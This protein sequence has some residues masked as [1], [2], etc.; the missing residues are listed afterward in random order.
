MNPRTRA[1]GA[2]VAGGLLAGAAVGATEALA[3]WMHAH[4]AG[5]PPA[6][7]WALVAYGLVGG[8]LGLGAGVLAAVLGTDGFGLGLAGVGAALGFAVAR[9]RVIR[10]VFLEQL[11][12]GPVPLLVQLGALAAVAAAGFALWR[13]LRGADGRRAPLTRPVVAG[14][15]VLLLAAA[16]A[17]GARLWPAP[18]AAAV[19][20]RAAAPAGAP[21]VLLIMV[22][23]LR[24]DHLSCYGS[25]RVRTP[26]I[27]AL[28]AG[29]LRCANT[30][31]QASWTRP[32]VATILT[33]LYPSSHGAIH[34]A[35]ILPDRVDTL[36][37]MLQRGG[38]RTI[39]FANNANV[40]Q[41]FN[42]QQG[43]DEYHYLAPDF[44]FGASE[45]AAQLALYSGLRLVRE[46]FL[47]RRVDVHNYYQPA[48]TVTGEVRRWL[49]GHPA[50][51]EPLF[52][53]VH[54]MDP[55]DPYFVHPFNGEGY[56][57][58]AHPNPPPEMADKLHGLY[59]GSVA[60]LDE[61]L[62]VLFDDLRKR[63]LY[64]RTLV[65]LT[66][67]HGEEFHEHGGWWHGT[68]LYD[69]Q[70]HVP[71]LVKPARPGAPG[72]VM[73]ELATSLD[74]M[75]T[76]LAAAKLPGPP[77]LQGHVL[78]LDG[79]APPARQ[80]VFAE[81]DLEGNVLQAVRTR[82]WKL[83]TANPGNPRGLAPEE[84]FDIPHDPGEHANAIGKAPAEAELMR[85]ELGQSVLQARAHAGATQQGGA[86]AATQERLRA[87]GY[88]E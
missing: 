38:Y 65:I 54:Y 74:I 14:V 16:A 36:A 18:P 32:S 2:A 80:S 15:V 75:P 22:D 69:E 87:L 31:S 88:V 19:A 50:G 13:A 28:A 70:I 61:H 44:F 56:A 66:S 4:G 76:I 53:F 83:V 47:A 60:Y 86:D 21:N 8:G 30:F 9:F 58:V 48:E 49:D 29:G 67:D 42:F 72:R 57:R 41:A 55:H 6:L 33:G 82:E 46:R 84:L 71:L 23:T 1:I 51:R 12:P 11:P 77:T 43:F 5:E 78:P 63:G 7:G 73:E 27:D 59:D 79:G 17:G 34:K 25:T 62:G 24:A 39:G 45:P 40:S 52:L 37:E 68:T 35:D 64:D 26:H 85:A 3:A 81:E 10:D 20:A